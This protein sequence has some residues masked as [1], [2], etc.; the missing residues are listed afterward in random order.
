MAKLSI[1]RAAESQMLLW[2]VC[3]QW[4][5][6]QGCA[7]QVQRGLRQNAAGKHNTETPPKKVDA[8]K[9]ACEGCSNVLPAT[10]G[11]LFDGQPN[12]DNHAFNGLEIEAANRIC[13]SHAESLSLSWCTTSLTGSRP[14]VQKLGTCAGCMYLCMYGCMCPFLSVC[15]H[16]CRQACLPA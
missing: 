7:D 14:Q 5:A 10:P 13:S 2:V 6:P 1:A 12:L 8:K 9:G 4:N 16:V 3:Y 11:C 15:I